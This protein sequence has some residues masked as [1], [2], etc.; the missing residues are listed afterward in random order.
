MTAPVAAPRRVPRA[1]TVGR[2]VA[3]IRDGLERTFPEAFWVEG[4]LG[5]FRVVASGHAFGSLKEEGSQVEVVMWR[6]AVG[7]LRFRP[8]EGM[9]VLARV[10]RVDFYAPQ[11]RLRVQIDRLE[12]DGVGAL[13][14]A[15]EELKAR[16]AA[17]GLFAPERKRPLPRLPRAIGI[18]T[19]LHGAA[20]RD[21]L[22][23]LERRYPDRRIVIRPCR[24]QGDGAAEDIAAAV[25]ELNRHGVVDVIIVGRGGGSAE[26]LWC[27]NHEVLVRAVARSRCPIVSAVGH[28]IDWTLTDLVADERAATPT[29][30]AQRVVPERRAIEASLADLAD[31]LRAALAR[32]HELARARL[33]ACEPALGT[34]QALLAERRLRLAARAQR[35]RQALEKLTPERRARLERLAHVLHR[36]LPDPAALASRLERAGAALRSSARTRFAL[37]RSG[38]EAQAARMEAFSP[39]G[40][41]ARGY[42]LVQREDGRVVR[43]AGDLARGESLRIRLARGAAKVDVVD[44]EA[45]EVDS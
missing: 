4:E 2:L 8:T 19:A 36:R 41:L 21:I 37:A 39:L 12:L 6:D 11:G 43:D 38:L 30:A 9:H 25:D 31:R 42:A 10:R 26:D 3:R 5:A 40:V 35:A 32:R 27:F 44:T 1:L 20:I 23:T 33:R 18:A 22:D 34:P 7:S 15:L 16:L 24:V 28:E 45:G 14:R 13:A 17:E 29:A